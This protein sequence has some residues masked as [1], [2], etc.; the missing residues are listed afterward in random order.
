MDHAVDPAQLLC[1]DMRQLTGFAEAHSTQSPLVARG[2]KQPA[3]DV[4]KI[5]ATT[6]SEFF[7]ERDAAT[8]RGTSCYDD[9]W[10]PQAS[11]RFSVDL[12]LVESGRPCYP[13]VRPTAGAVK[14]DCFFLPDAVDPRCSRD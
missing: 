5:S 1:L 11:V 2:A 12:S 10:Q 6:L 4:T 8:E 7:R 13:S 3:R 9:S 14:P